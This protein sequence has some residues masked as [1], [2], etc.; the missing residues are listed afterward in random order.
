MSKLEFESPRHEISHI[1]HGSREPLSPKQLLPLCQLVEDERQLSNYLYNMC[2][3]E[4]LTRHPA[5]EGSGMGVKFLYG[6]GPVKLGA[7]AS[8]ENDAG[9]GR[10]HCPQGAR[11]A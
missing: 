7:I 8:P 6:P 11:Y 9:G 1:V 4:Q 10:P 5:P 3:D 2:K